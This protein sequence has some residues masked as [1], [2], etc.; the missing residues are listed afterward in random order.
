MIGKDEI[1]AAMD[2]EV[3]AKKDTITGPGISDEAA[4]RWA[5]QYARMS[6]AEEGLEE[7]MPGLIRRYHKEGG[8]GEPTEDEAL[9]AFH[10]LN[11]LILGIRI[12]RNDAAA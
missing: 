6:S 4:I 3:L 5:F 12:G 2:E 11:A 10:V 9:M 1:A 7:L 8:R